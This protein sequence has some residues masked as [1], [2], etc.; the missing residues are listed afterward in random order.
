MKLK[1]LKPRLHNIMFHTH[2]V[3]GIVISFA[4]FVIF[5]AGAFSLFRGELYRWENPKA[6]FDVKENI[7][8]DSIINSI[9]NYDPRYK[10]VNNFTISPSKEENPFISFFARIKTP[11]GKNKNIS[12]YINPHTGEKLLNPNKFSVPNKSLTYMGETLYRL[13][14]FRQLIPSVGIYISGLVSFFFLFA[15]VTGVLIHWKNIVAKFHAFTIKGKWKQIWTNTHT[16]LG[17]IALP[18]Q[19]IYAITGSLLGLSI[20]LLAPSA[21]LLFDGDRDEIINLVRPENAIKYSENAEDSNTSIHINSFYDEV[22]NKYPNHE[23][24][25]IAARN[26]GKV[27]GSLIFTLD[28]KT[29]V[30]GNGQVIYTYKEGVFTSQTNLGSKTYTQGA[31]D[32]LIKLHY[33]NYGGYFLKIIYFILA[34]MTCY[35]IISGILIWQKARDNKKYT[36]KQRSF[37][38]RVTKVYLS[39]CLSMFPAFALI[40]IANKIVPLN[41][42]GRVGYVQTIFFA[43]WGLLTIIG[44]FW[45]HY[46]KLNKNYLF[47]GSVLAL[48]IPVVNGIVTKDWIWKTLIHKQYYVFSVDFAWLLTGVF[49]LIISNSLSILKSNAEIEKETSN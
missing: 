1:P 35:I 28:D 29:G 11:E 47:I 10:D 31:Y 38:H 44:L 20:L 49:G 22:H 17:T 42:E 39:I 18:F 34:M 25:R 9:K 43:G 12:Y 23:I 32:V 21:Y 40:F 30:A 2:T 5:Y 6:R 36:D 33:A 46:N 15:I 27:D 7:N 41:L 4:L 24:R 8:Y 16:T 37:H 19:F 14:Y 48:F 45:N 3:A 13:H 26:H